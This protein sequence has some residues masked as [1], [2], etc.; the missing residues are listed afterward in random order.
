MKKEPQIYFTSDQHFY[1]KNIITL[2]NRPFTDIKSMN[3]FMIKQWNSVITNEDII[4]H[5][6]D[7]AFANKQKTT[8]IVSR[9]NGKK[10]IVLGNH[11]RGRN[12][13]FYYDCGFDKV[14]DQNII[15]KDY[16]ILSHEPLSY[17]SINCP[18]HNIHGHCHNSPQYMTFNIHSTCV[19]VERHNYLPISMFRILK[20]IQILMNLLEINKS[21]VINQFNLDLRS[22]YGKETTINKVG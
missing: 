5:L 1:H 8:D 2:E 18:Y 20:N 12:V 14:Y 21:N 16:F 13:K 19:C 7:F 11:D 22:L 17:M 4:Y 9:L 15:I 10:Y 3:E 6:G